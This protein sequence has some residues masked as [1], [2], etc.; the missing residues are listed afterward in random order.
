MTGTPLFCCRGEGG[1]GMEGGRGQMDGG[2][3]E[4]GGRKYD[5]RDGGRE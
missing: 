3:G 1:G 4:D 5:W 2:G